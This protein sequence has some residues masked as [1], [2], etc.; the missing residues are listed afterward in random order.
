[1]ATFTIV[2]ETSENV[3]HDVD[4]H[5][6]IIIGGICL[7]LLFLWGV[8]AALS[9]VMSKLKSLFT[10]VLISTI[11]YVMYDLAKFALRSNVPFKTNFE[12]FSF[13]NSTVIP[14]FTSISPSFLYPNANTVQTL[15]GY[16]KQWV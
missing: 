14:M 13:L 2:N 7:L 16:I 9:F 6:L 10:T 4:E 15:F 11:T 1:M 12:M 3:Q 8:F 5:V